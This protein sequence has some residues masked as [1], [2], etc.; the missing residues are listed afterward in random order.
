MF[1]APWQRN[2]ANILIAIVTLQL[3]FTA[4]WAAGVTPTTAG[5]TQD[6][7]ANGVP[8]VNIAAPNAGGLS[9]NSYSQFNVNSNG[10]IFNNSAQPVNTQLGGYI[11]GNANMARRI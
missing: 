1:H 5:I 11:L 8:I 7:A 9:H 6:Q 3:F 4:A 2:I 10:L